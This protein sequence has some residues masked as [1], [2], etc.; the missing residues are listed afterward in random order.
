MFESF[1]SLLES[2]FEN[3]YKYHAGFR[4][5]FYEQLAINGK[6]CKVA[7]QREDVKGDRVQA[8][9]DI[10]SWLDD[11]P[12]FSEKTSALMLLQELMDPESYQIQHDIVES[13]FQLARVHDFNNYYV[14]VINT[15]ENFELLQSTPHKGILDLAFILRYK[16]VAE[17]HDVSG[18]VIVNDEFC[19]HFNVDAEE[20]FEFVSNKCKDVEYSLIGLALDGEIDPPFMHM[21]ELEGYGLG[22]GMIFYSGVLAEIADE[23]QSNLLILPSSTQELIVLDEHAM[24]G[25]IIGLRIIVSQV[26]ATL[27]ADKYLSDSVYRWNR[28]EGKLEIA[29]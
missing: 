14:D 1:C 11:H 18:V 27:P 10:G 2:E 15:K 5:H 23:F 13:A 19:S 6:R 17:E 22:S 28:A 24:S 25:S 20:V 8:A 4:L 12:G 29:E 3:T 16:I 21:P 26:N 7:M 9:F